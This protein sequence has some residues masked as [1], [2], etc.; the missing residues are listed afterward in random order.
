MTTIETIPDLTKIEFTSFV[1]SGGEV[2]IKITNPNSVS[3]ADA[4]RITA[5]LVNTNSIFELAFLVDAIR[6]IN[7]FILIHLNCPYFPAARQDRVMVDGESLALKV[8]ADFINSLNFTIVEVWDVHSDVS[9]AVINRVHNIGPEVF[10]EK[11]FDKLSFDQLNKYVLVS[12]DAG[13]M[14]KVGKVAKKFNLPMI[15]A[16]KI[17]N[18][19]NGEI[20][21]TE[22]HIPESARF[23]TFLIVDDI[24]DGG[25]TFTELAKAI[26]EQHNIGALVP[27]KIEL[28]VTHGIFSKGLDVITEAGISHIYTANPFPNV[29]LTNQNLT[30]LQV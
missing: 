22:I 9:L 7:P 19:K 1:F 3:A 5:Q 6:R 10:L 25:R 11:A 29:D 18:P 8:I 26:N 2:Q 15:T 30:V 13:A 12:P 27:A 28:Y 23:K 24:C 21:G 14:K 17:R 4:L 20:T 16:S